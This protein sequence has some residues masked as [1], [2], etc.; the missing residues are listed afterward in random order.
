MRYGTQALDA[1]RGDDASTST[2]ST[3]AGAPAELYEQLVSL[4]LLRR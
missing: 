2:H 3:Q 1:A 4:G